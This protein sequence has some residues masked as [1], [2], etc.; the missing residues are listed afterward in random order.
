MPT[1]TFNYVDYSAKSSNTLKSFIEG[2]AQDRNQDRLKL[3]KQ[4]KLDPD[5]FNRQNQ[6]LT[7]QDQH[8]ES[9]P[10]T[11]RALITIDSKQ[12]QTPVKKPRQIT[13]LQ[14]ATKIL[15][16]DRTITPQDK[17]KPS[18][19]IDG[20]DYQSKT[21]DQDRTLLPQLSG[22]GMLSSIEDRN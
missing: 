14:Q 21:R 18:D 6:T 20:R 4:G 19:T 2:S 7:H 16:N 8:Q 22:T 3:G 10:V 13:Q 17:W 5:Y 9:Y 12:I 1:T 15:T 11:T